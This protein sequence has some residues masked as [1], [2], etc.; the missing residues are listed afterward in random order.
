MNEIGKI[1]TP[2]QTKFGVPKQGGMVLSDLSYIELSPNYSLDSVRGLDN[3]QFIWVLWLFHQCEGK[4]KELIRPPKLGGNEKMGVFGARSPFRP[5]NIAMTLVRLLRV[6]SQYSKIR[7]IIE[8]ADMV[9]GTP[10]LDIKPYHPVADTPW[11]EYP[12]P[13][14]VKESLE[15]KKVEFSC[16]VPK[17]HKELIE[18]VL[19]LD[20]RPAYHNDPNRIYVNHLRRLD[21]HWKVNDDI[22]EVVKTVKKESNDLA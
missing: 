6:E 19:R 9:T 17:E 15:T 12:T 21:V 13:W 18:E 7:L 22:I 8:G 2:Y 10:V 14:F 3:G 1:H 5:N 16:E 20:P 4:E 11:A